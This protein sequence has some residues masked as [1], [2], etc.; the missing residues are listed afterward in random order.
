[1]R[2]YLTLLF[3]AAFAALWLHAAP[4]ASATPLFGFNDAWEPSDVAGALSVARSFGSNSAR[5]QIYWGSYE[6]RPGVYRFAG[7]DGTYA[8]MLAQGIRPLIDVV[9]APSWATAPGCNDIYRCQQSPQHDGAFAAF[10]RFLV[11]RYP[12]AVGIEIGNEPN[13]HEWSVHPDPARYA[14][15]LKTGYTAV[16]QADPAMPVISAG[17]CCNTAN[18]NGD[19]GAASF[20]AQLYANGIQGYYDYI[21]VHLYP[22]RRVDQVAPDLETELNGMRAARNAAG[23][24]SGFWVTETGFP[25]AGVSAYGGGTYDESNQAQREA[26]DYRVVTSQPDVGAL[27]FYRLTDPPAG[28]ATGSYMGLYHQDLSPKPAAQALLAAVHGPGWPQYKVVVKAPAAAPAGKRFRVR[29]VAQGAPSAAY[30]QWVVWHGD[31]WSNPVASSAHPAARL[32]FAAAGRYTIAVRMA[33]SL[34]S[35][36]SAPATIQVGSRKRGGRRRR[37]ARSA[38]AGGALTSR[39]GL[40]PGTTVNVGAPVRFTALASEP[41]V[42]AAWSFGASGTSVEHAFT[43]P[44]P[45]TVRLK[46]SDARG[47]TAQASVQVT[48]E[49]HPAPVAAL[50]AASATVSPGGTVN[51]DATGSRAPGGDIVEYEWDPGSGGFSQGDDSWTHTY[52]TPGTYLARVRVTD[53]SGAQTIATRTITVLPYPP[54]VAHIVCSSTEVR[55]FAGLYCYSDDSRSPYPVTSHTWTIGPTGTT[56][57]GSSVWSSWTAPGAGTVTLTVTDSNGNSAT[58]SVQIK[59]D[60]SAPVARISSPATIAQNVPLTFDGSSSSDSAGQ[61]VSWQWDDGQGAGLRSGG[62]TFT[63]TYANAGWYDVRLRATNDQG[64]R[65]TASDWIYV[66]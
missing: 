34:D 62:T 32:R 55:A 20:L 43:S 48:A 10:L 49:T 13:L 46:V 17:I 42:R 16:K 5:L 59:V 30:Y 28:E 21:G 29:V 12:Q 15:I 56:S 35:Y 61:I 27:Y 9:S 1:M 8:S 14:Q 41:G 2:R 58:T 31:H 66:P 57:S 52:A 51:F 11:A 19:I 22:G 25:S 40:Y 60:D 33:T 65:S 63:A 64:M 7:I 54:P 50:T 18:A 44:G 26:I 23:D 47:N 45:Y 39:I 4:P 53:D 36:L 3:V 37:R 38:A 24:A 6:P